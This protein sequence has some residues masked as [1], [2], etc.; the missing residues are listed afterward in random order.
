MHLVEISVMEQR[1]QAVMAVVQDG[2][3]GTEVADR[4]GSRVKASTTGS[5]ATRL[6]DCPH[7]RTDRIGRPPEQ[8]D[9]D[10]PFPQY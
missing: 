8:K 5:P 4:R 9:S 6:A 10:E 1:Y 2:L 3:K 7:S